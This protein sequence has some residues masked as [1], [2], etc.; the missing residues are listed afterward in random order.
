MTTVSVSPD[1]AIVFSLAA[2]YVRR[3]AEV[4]RAWAL[5]H[6]EDGAITVAELHR[7]LDDL[8]PIDMSYVAD[9]CDGIELARKFASLPEIGAEPQAVSS[10][11]DEARSSDDASADR[12]SAPI[13]LLPGE[14]GF[15]VKV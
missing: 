6:S 1:N 8:D 11:N 9:V 4:E 7:L 13:Y 5:R 2:R 15:S 3:L 12:S 10:P 14:P